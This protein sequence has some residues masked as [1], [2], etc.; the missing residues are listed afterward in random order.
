MGSYAIRTRRRSPNTLFRFRTFSEKEL[1]KDLSLGPFWEPFS[2]KIVILSEKG[3]QKSLQKKGTPQDAN[4]TLWPSP[5][6]P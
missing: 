3:L 1:P 2:V 5:E 4:G 6:A